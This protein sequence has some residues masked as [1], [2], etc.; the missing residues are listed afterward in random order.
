MVLGYDLM[1]SG[2]ITC[3]ILLFL[4]LI[5]TGKTQ[6]N[7]YKIKNSTAQGISCTIASLMYLSHLI[8]EMK[9][10]TQKWNQFFLFLWES[11]QLLPVFRCVKNSETSNIK[12][13][14]THLAFSRCLFP[15]VVSGVSSIL[16]A[17]QWKSL[18]PYTRLCT[19]PSALCQLV[20]WLLIFMYFAS[21]CPWVQSFQFFD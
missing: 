3:L 2:S 7:R 14:D 12:G 17:K 6:S 15:S 5:K 19:E 8:T 10:G 16:I 1:F 13:K 11:G 18:E 20:W 21:Q 4:S 9:K